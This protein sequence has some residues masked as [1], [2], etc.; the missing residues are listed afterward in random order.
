MIMTN[1]IKSTVNKIVDLAE[2]KELSAFD[3]IEL[4]TSI[5]N[6]AIN[7][8]YYQD[9]IKEEYYVEFAPKVKEKRKESISI[10]VPSACI[11]RTLGLPSS[12]LEF[13]K[14]QKQIFYDR[15]IS[16]NSPLENRV[17]S[18]RGR[19]NIEREDRGLRNYLK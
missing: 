1:P 2:T 6:S 7:E 19:V 18:L 16:I 11:I 14:D 4:A 13:T 17:I 12:I 15:L 10:E 9:I 5:D 8:V 3:L